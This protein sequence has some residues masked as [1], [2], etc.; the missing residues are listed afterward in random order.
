MSSKNKKDT[1]KIKSA[2]IRQLLLKGGRKGAKLEFF[3][4]V[5]RAVLPNG[6]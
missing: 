2:E 6:N 3:E 4:L 1:M 5:K